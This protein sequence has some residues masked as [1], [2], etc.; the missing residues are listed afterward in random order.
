MYR[1]AETFVYKESKLSWIINKLFMKAYSSGF[2]FYYQV[3]LYSAHKASDLCAFRRKPTVVGGCLY[4]LYYAAERARLYLCECV[5]AA[6]AGRKSER[7]HQDESREKL[8][9]QKS[10]PRI[11]AILQS[12]LG[13]WF[14]MN[15]ESTPTSPTGCWFIPCPQGQFCLFLSL[16][17]SFIAD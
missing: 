4:V 3:Y 6:A 5:C 15:L 16:C 13:K 2:V 10:F 7:A 9:E 17:L 14:L 11:F 12:A 1:R 8:G